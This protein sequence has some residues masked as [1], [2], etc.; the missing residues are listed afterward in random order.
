MFD[1][2]KFF[3]GMMDFFSILLP[4]AVLTYL[5]SDVAGAPIFKDDPIPGGAEG[6]IVF[7]FSSY[8]LGHLVF[9]GT[10][11]SPLDPGVADRVNIFAAFG[12]VVAA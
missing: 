10:T 1:P 12:F 3:I 5:F 6:W 11:L 2:Q 9:L 8:L 4:G 7:I